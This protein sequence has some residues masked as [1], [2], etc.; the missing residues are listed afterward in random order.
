MRLEQALQQQRAGLLASAVFA[1]AVEH[2]NLCVAQG[3]L[4]G[5][6][7]AA[8][9]LRLLAHAQQGALGGCPDALW[10][11]HSGQAFFVAAWDDDCGKGAQEQLAQWHQCHL[12]ALGVAGVVFARFYDLACPVGECGLRPARRGAVGLRLKQRG[13]ACLPV[14]ALQHGTARIVLR[15]PLPL[16]CVVQDAAHI[17]QP[18]LQGARLREGLAPLLYAA[19]ECLR[20]IDADVAIYVANGGVY[21]IF[22]RPFLPI[23]Q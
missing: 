23:G 6:A 7:L 14:Q 2:I 16:A 9:Q 20:C 11:W 22:L 12:L 21:S 8:L 13:S 5:A 17:G 3:V 10:F 19:G 1:A 4:P 15:Q 18:L